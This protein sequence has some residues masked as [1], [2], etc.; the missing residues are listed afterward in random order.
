MNA[1]ECSGD[2]VKWIYN[3]FGDCIVTVTDKVS[4]VFGLM[5]TLT[6]IYAQLPQI[7]LNCMNH[8]A[9][10]V[11][12]SYYLFVIVGDTGNVIAVFLN[13]TMVTQKF[14]AI[15]GLCADSFTC[16]QY[17][18]Y[19]WVKPWFTGVPCI[20]P[21]ADEV[22]DDDVEGRGDGLQIPMTPLLIASA[23]SLSLS[24]DNPYSSKNLL[25]TCLGWVGGITFVAGRIPQVVKNYKRKRTT[26]LSVQFWICSVF[27]NSCYGVSILTKSPTWGYLW[28]QMPWFFGSVGC[29]PLDFT[30]LIQFC[31]YRWTNQK[32]RRQGCQRVDSL[33]SL[34]SDGSHMVD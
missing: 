15:W 33:D 8:S 16:L 19:H 9:E 13:D 28:K 20:D 23:A 32:R 3:I 2:Y 18:Y 6:W 24:P 11:S 5:V 31:Y 29:L 30:I 10:A 17:I 7:V 22:D 14:A 1:E 25:G 4:F 21:G 26:G 12:L 27:A 34:M